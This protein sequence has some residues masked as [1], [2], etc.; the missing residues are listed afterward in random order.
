MSTKLAFD[1]GVSLQTDHMIGTSAHAPQCSM[2]LST[3]TR[4]IEKGRSRVTTSKEDPYVAL[5]ARCLKGKIASE[6]FREL[7]AASGTTASRKILYRW[8]A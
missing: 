5:N 4:R 3:V 8:L 1:T 6:L 7:T 2:T